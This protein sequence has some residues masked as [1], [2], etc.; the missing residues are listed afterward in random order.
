MDRSKEESNASNERKRCII[1]CRGATEEGVAQQ[2]AG[3]HEYAKVHDLEV[4]DVIRHVGGM[5]VDLS[6]DRTIEPARARER[7]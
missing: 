3:L 1:F 7:Q 6:G 2:A 5:P 4:I